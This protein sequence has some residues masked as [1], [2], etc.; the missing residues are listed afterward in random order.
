M[1]LQLTPDL[2]QRLE[3]LAAESHCSPDELA[4]EALDRFVSYR[5]DLLA[6]LQQARESA[7]R[8]GWLT[9]EEVL[10]RIAKRFKAA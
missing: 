8:D 1:A 5:E 3:H 9:S 2:E 4:Q 7:D 10:E 6:T